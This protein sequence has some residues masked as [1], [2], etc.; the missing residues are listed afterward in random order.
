MLACASEDCGARLGH[1][2]P[3]MKQLEIPAV[4]A[5]EDTFALCCED[6]QHDDDTDSD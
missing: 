3:C 4:N 1:I 6:M 2:R 5:G